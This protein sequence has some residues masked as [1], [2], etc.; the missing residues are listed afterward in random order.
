[1]TAESSGAEGEE[2]VAGHLE[3]T[4]TSRGFDHMPL[5][6][7]E[8]GGFVSVYESSAALSPHIWLRAQSERGDEVTLHLTAD[9][10]RKLAEQIAYLVRH[11]YQG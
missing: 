3:F 11:H 4:T 5:I 1:M 7:G 8:Y 6:A 2:G 10:A 9:N